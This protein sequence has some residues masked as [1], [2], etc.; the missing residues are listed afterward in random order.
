VPEQQE[1]EN[2]TDEGENDSTTDDDIGEILASMSRD[3][4]LRLL[5]TAMKDGQTSTLAAPSQS[6]FPVVDSGEQRHHCWFSCEWGFRICIFTFN[7]HLSRCISSGSVH[8]GRWP[9]CILLT[10]LNQLLFST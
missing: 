1:H 5:P 8:R 7:Y 4:A 2:S 3:D 9:I 6:V 10:G